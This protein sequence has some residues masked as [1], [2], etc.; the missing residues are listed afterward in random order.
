MI[1]FAIYGIQL[2]LDIALN[3]KDHQSQNYHSLTDYQQ[4]Q[5]QQDPSNDKMFSGLVKNTRFETEEAVN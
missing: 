5:Q 3:R 1:Q 4:L 2:V